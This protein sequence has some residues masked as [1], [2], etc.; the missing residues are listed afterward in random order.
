MSWRRARHAG[1]TIAATST[2]Q[3]KETGMN[4]PKRTSTPKNDQ[5]PGHYGAGYGE[6]VPEDAPPQL[7]PATDGDRPP[8]TGEGTERPVGETPATSEGDDGEPVVFT[9]DDVHARPPDQTP[10]EAAPESEKVG[11]IFERS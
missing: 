10:T 9:P 3:P 1:A 11:L 2:S 6:Q 8:G 7:G 5:E 4:E